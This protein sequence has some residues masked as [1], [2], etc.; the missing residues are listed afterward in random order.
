[1]AQALQ[2]GTSAVLLFYN[3]LIFHIDLTT[4]FGPGIASIVSGGK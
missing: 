3:Y 4:H 1:M 2:S